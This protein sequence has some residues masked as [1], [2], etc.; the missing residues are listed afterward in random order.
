MAKVDWVVA[1]A[2]D[3]VAAPLVILEAFQQRRPVIGAE[4]E[5][6]AALVREG[7]NGLMFQRGDAADLART[8]RRAIGE[9]GL[10]DRLTAGIPPCPSL[11]ESVDR[12]LALYNALLR[13]DDK[14]KV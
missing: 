7:V 8:M 6:V 11:A 9:A 12:H 13:A 3:P 2:L 5:G 14:L 1:P 10:W 4:V